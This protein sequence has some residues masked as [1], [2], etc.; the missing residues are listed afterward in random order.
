MR[1]QPLLCWLITG[2]IWLSACNVS[3]AGQPT[4]PPTYV[5][6][7]YTNLPLE[8][9]DHT[10]LP[11]PGI[12][13]CKLADLRPFG[14]K[15]VDSG[16]VD[17]RTPEE[18]AI[19]TGSLYREGYLDYRQG[20]VEYPDRYQ[21]MPELSYEE[22]LATCNVFPEVDFEK[23]SLLGAQA[24]GAGC[25]VDFEKHVYRDDQSQT[26]RYEVAVIE[27]GACDTVTHNRNLI[28]VPRISPEYRVKFFM[29]G[30]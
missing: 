22:F 13:G 19:Q 1:Q 21:S 30:E 3:R 27:A 8:E 2:F 15:E 29:S 20:R 9:L 28:L 7:P 26:V 4:L 18:Y 5:E 25:T 6:I 16:L 14:W 23:Y 10:L 24:T 12:P 17:I 11:E